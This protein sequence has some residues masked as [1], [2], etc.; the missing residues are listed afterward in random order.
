MRNPGQ[1]E[2]VGSP[3]RDYQGK[4]R[5]RK[6]AEKIIQDLKQYMNDPDGFPTNFYKNTTDET[7]IPRQTVKNW[8]LKLK[9]NPD[10]R[11]WNNDHGK[12]RRIFTDAEEQ[13]LRDTI[14]EEYFDNDEFFDGKEFVELAMNKYDEKV[15]EM[16]EEAQA[17]Y[18]EAH[19][20]SCSNRFIGNF[21]K[22]NRCSSRR[23]HFSR[24][25]KFS[26]NTAT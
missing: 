13:E 5:G 7:G 3:H 12:H 21:M 1:V 14:K 16:D 11:P 26:E 25:P 22:R 6:A 10:W 4:G 23:L 8:L 24:R 15:G 17:A 9:G 20:F 18:M 2:H 19:P